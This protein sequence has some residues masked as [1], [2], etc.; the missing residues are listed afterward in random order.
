MKKI[1]IVSYLFAPENAIG[2]IRPTKIAKFLSK[3]AYDITVITS[4]NKLKHDSLLEKD[5]SKINKIIELDHSE[6]YTKKFIKKNSETVITKDSHSTKSTN[7]KNNKIK[8]QEL[9]FFKR[10]SLLFISALDFY[11]QC[12]KL[13]SN[14][15]IDINDYDY[16]FTT[17]GPVSSILI[18]LWLK[19]RYPKLIWIN[20]FRDPMVVND[21]PFIFKNIYKWLQKKSCEKANY[22]V[23]ISNGCLKQICGDKFREKTFV[24]TNGYDNDDL[25]KSVGINDSGK[26]SF[27][28]AGSLYEGKRDLSPLFNVLR[29]LVN[30]E[31]INLND[32]EFNY[33]GSDFK[34]LE[35]QAVKYE[36]HSILVNH[37]V[38]PREKSIQLQISSKFLV[39]S[40]WNS[41][42]EEG[43]LTGK[44]FEYMLMN[45][46]IIGLING[47]KSESETKIIINKANIGI[48]YEQ[49]NHVNDYFQL[50]NYILNQYTNFKVNNSSEYHPN[51]NVIE[52][53][54]YMNIVD[55]FERNFLLK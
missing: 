47:N 31:S 21:T 37:G 29:E 25:D 24:M 9:R 34:V 5:L 55:K 6:T 27:V 3:K 17:F 14:R 15:E 38:L 49:A 39:L 1:L 50:K 8:F 53:Y 41:D 26:F 54:N 51:K 45:K 42:V 23:S 10:N 44:F 16:V 40:T 13:I 22:I 28:Y 52:E 19:K 7:R 30:N 12:K 46:P 33:A 48:S 18:G 35:Q 11:N 20:D 36:L 43:V 32:I 4:S 2:A